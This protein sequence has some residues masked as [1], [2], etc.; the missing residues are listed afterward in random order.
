MAN[1][2]RNKNIG[3]RL[4]EQE[5]MQIKSKIDHSNLTQQE[6]FLRCLLKKEIHVKEGGLDVVKSLKAIG[7]N[8][9]QI[10]YKVNAGQIMDCSELLKRIYEEVREIRITWQ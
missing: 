1:R 5:F 9:N 10:A 2:K 6:Y 4:T 3:V 7:N 8:L